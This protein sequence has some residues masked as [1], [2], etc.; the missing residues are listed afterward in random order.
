MNTISL[1]KFKAYKAGLSVLY[2]LRNAG[3]GH[4]LAYSMFAGIMAYTYIKGPEVKN[5]MYR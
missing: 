4:R 3:S 1:F 5:E 2:R